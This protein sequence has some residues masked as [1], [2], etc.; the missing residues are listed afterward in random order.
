MTCGCLYSSHC[1]SLEHEFRFMPTA[2]QGT[3]AVLFHGT[4][5]ELVRGKN[6]GERHR[7]N[8]YPDNEM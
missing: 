6:R 5:M 3:L 1:T 4:H 2:V 8:K 7:H